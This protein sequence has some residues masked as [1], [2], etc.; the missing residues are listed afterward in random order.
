LVKN[1]HAFASH[2][3]LQTTCAKAGNNRKNYKPFENF[4]RRQYFCDCSK[5]KNTQNS[6]FEKRFPVTISNF[7]QK[8]NTRSINFREK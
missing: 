2:A 1:R 8:N 6:V 4:K 5:R 3:D 7:W